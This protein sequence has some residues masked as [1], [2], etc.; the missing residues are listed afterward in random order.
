MADKVDNVLHGVEG[1]P[2][3]LEAYAGAW[4][5]KALQYLACDAA[6]PPERHLL[7]V[8]LMKVLQPAVA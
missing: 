1:D 2:L 3:S 7:F 6:C 8:V 5:R 4:V